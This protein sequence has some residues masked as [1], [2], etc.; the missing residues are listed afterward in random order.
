MMFSVFRFLYSLETY[1]LHLAV[2]LRSYSF[3]SL[4]ANSIDVCNYYKVSYGH[5]IYP[6]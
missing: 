4:I 6:R 2:S 5:Y 1:Y 3:T